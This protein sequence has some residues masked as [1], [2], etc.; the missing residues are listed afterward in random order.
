MPQVFWC[1]CVLVAP[2]KLN[3]FGKFYPLNFVP[4]FSC[5]CSFPL[6]GLVF[7]YPVNKEVDDRGN[8]TTIYKA[9]CFTNGTYGVCKLLDETSALSTVPLP[10][11][12]PTMETPVRV[13]AASRGR[14]PTG[15][16]QK[17]FTAAGLPNPRVP[18]GA[19]NPEQ[20]G[21]ARSSQRSAASRSA[22]QRLAAPLSDSA[23]F[24]TEPAAPSRAS[25]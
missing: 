25:P 21:A 1:V 4:L 18:L 13:T 19:T 2:R 6:R 14:P 20:H 23:E 12:T 11:S 10:P 8:N 3:N 15:T 17:R 5:L 16:R 9:S 7:N 24:V 22:A